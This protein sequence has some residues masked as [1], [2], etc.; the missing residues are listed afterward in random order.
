MTLMGLQKC[1][2]MTA[3]CPHYQTG[4]DDPASNECHHIKRT[5]ASMVNALVSLDMVGPERLPPALLQYLEETKDFLRETDTRWRSS[6]D[7]LR[8]LASIPER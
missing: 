1:P 3:R 8:G 6:Q 5:T 7:L 4:C 2:H